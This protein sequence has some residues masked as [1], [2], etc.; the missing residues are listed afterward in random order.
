MRIAPVGDV[1]KAISKQLGESFEPSMSLTDLK[2]TVYVKKVPAGLVLDKIANV[3]GCAWRD[4]HGLE[5]LV[6]LQDEKDRRQG[7]LDKEASVLRAEAEKQAHSLA[8]AAASASSLEEFAQSFSHDQPTQPNGGPPGPAHFPRVRLVSPSA[9]VASPTT[10]ALGKQWA[11]WSPSDWDAFWSGNVCFAQVSY[12]QPSGG[13]PDTQARR[14]RLPSQYVFARY[15]LYGDNHLQFAMPPHGSIPRTAPE[16]KQL[17]PTGEL[18]ATPFGK[19]V[20][21]WTDT[22]A[23]DKDPAFSQVMSPSK[24]PGPQGPLIMADQLAWLYQH[25]GIPIVADAFRNQMP[26]DRK[27]LGATPASWLSSLQSVDRC[28]VR[29]EDGV[30]MVR[31]GGFWHLRTMEIPETLIQ[32][33]AQKNEPPTLWEY[34]SFLA[35]LTPAQVALLPSLNPPVLD[36]PTEPIAYAI[37]GLR[38]LGSLGSLPQSNTPIPYSELSSSAQQMYQAALYEAMFQGGNWTGLGPGPNPAKYMFELKAG[39]VMDEG[40]VVPGVTLVFGTSDQQAVTYI[41]AFPPG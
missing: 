25:S 13:N 21:A 10:Y 2:L 30:V 3:L 17:R 16:E 36:F 33:L 26:R 4:E 11:T 35:A 22:S 37:P 8:D 29:I 14:I 19:E 39:D 1:L 5:M 41:V 28:F 34:A 7:Y 24:D 20:L 9:T 12:D 23:A 38:F 15:D 40:R 32:P 18:A 27:P 6:M 31:H